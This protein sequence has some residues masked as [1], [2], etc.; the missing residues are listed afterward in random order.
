NVAIGGTNV[1]MVD[2]VGAQF[3]GL[4]DSDAL[5]TELGGHRTSPLLEVAAKRFGIDIRA[6]GVVGD[7]ASLLA[8]KRPA[9][10][11]GM[12]GFDIDDTNAHDHANNVATLP[13]EIHAVKV[14]GVPLIDGTADAV[15]A[16]ATPI[17]FATDWAGTATTT[18]TNVR[19]L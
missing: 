1:V 13:K 18:S 5:A 17:A 16:A 14:E 6:P 10:L 12:A 15:W 9:H 4:W 19:V 3:L 2:R 8:T 11:I 7:G